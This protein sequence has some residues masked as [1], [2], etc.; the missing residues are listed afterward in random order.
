MAIKSPVAS[1]DEY[2]KATR[3]RFDRLTEEWKSFESPFSSAMDLAMHPAY[4][5]IIGMGPMAIPW[6]IEQLEREPDHWFWALHCL[7][8][9]LDPV[10]HSDRGDMGAMSAAWI[11]WARDNGY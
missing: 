8:G 1:A 5:Q 7:S 2:L 3:V 11:K 10:P 6:I 4:Q 9:G